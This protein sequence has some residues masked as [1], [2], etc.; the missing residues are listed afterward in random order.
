MLN[1][2][3]TDKD[4]CFV[5]SGLD[6]GHWKLRAEMSLDKEKVET[7]PEHMSYCFP[8]RLLPLPFLLTSSLMENYK[9]TSF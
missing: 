1:W 9:S 7:T 8:D 5:P 4:Q 3:A 2:N 6:V